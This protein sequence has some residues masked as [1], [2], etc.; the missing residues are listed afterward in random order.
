MKGFVYRGRY[1]HLRP[2]VAKEVIIYINISI[3][4]LFI[5]WA[6]PALVMLCSLTDLMDVKHEN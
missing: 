6:N 2:K 1:A 5:V 4:I 3:M